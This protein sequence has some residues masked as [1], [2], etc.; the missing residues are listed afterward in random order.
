MGYESRFYIVNKTSVVMPNNYNNYNYCSYG[1]LIASFNLCYSSDMW[2]KIK[3]YRYT[4]CY[5]YDN[6]SQPIYYDKYGERLK[7]IPI[8]DL[9]EILAN[10]IK[11]DDC[12]RYKPLL[13]LLMG[14]DLKQWDNLV[15][16]HYRY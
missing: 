7:E 10:L 8:N 13:I 6:D 14:F 3:D 16:L 15:V 9:I 5:F 12:R 1:E 2:E 11:T 4:D